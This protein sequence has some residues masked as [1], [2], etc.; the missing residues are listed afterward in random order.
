[1]NDDLMVDLYEDDEDLMTSYEEKEE[2]N[3]EDKEP[4]EI[5]LVGV[6]LEDEL[7]YILSLIKR[8]E[9]DSDIPLYL[10]IDNQRQL[11]GRIGLSYNLFLRLYEISPKYTL[12]LIDNLNGKSK[13]L[14]GKDKK[15]DYKTLVSLMDL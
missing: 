12:R 8:Y 7:H 4:M 13:I 14:I 11:I 5:E 9:S 10:V 6:I 15:S 2:E 1:M 3:S